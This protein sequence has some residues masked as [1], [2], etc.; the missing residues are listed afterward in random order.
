MRWIL[1]AVIALS[2]IA[3][4]RATT[5]YLAPGTASPAGRD[6]NT[7]LDAAHP[8]LSPNHSLNCG[9][10]IVAAAGTYSAWNFQG[11][12][13]GTVS[14]PANNNVAMLTCA[15]FDGCKISSTSF[16][17]YVSKSY[18]G[19]S[20]WEAT[21]SS[22]GHS[23]FAAAPPQSGATASIHH[24]IFAN[25]IANGA[26][27]GGFSTFAVGAYGV[28]Y[29]AMIGDIAYNAAQNS[30]QCYSGFSIYR[31]AQ[32][33]SV[34]GTHIYLAGNYSFGN[35]QPATCDPHSDP[36]PGADGYIIDT[37][38]G[39]FVGGVPDSGPGRFTAQ[40]ALENNYAIGN[41]GRGL[42]VQDNNTNPP[43]HA[44]VFLAH[45]TDWGNV[46]A[47]HGSSSLCADLQLNESYGINA[48]ANL[49]VTTQAKGCPG[50]AG[51]TLYPSKAWN[52]SSSNVPSGALTATN[53]PSSVTGNL[54]F[55]PNGT[56]LS[57]LT[58][59]WNADGN[60][61]KYGSNVT[62]LNPAFPGAAVPSAPSCGGFS[63]VAACMA[64]LRSNFTPSAKGAATYGVQAISTTSVTNGLYPQ[65]LCS[66]SSLPSG[67]VTPGCGPSTY[68]LTVMAPTNGTITG[69]LCSSGSY[70][71][72][73]SISCT[74]TPASGYT[75][76]GWSGACSGTEACLFTLSASSTVAAS[77]T[78]ILT[79]TLT[80][81]AIGSGTMRVVGDRSRAGTDY[82]CTLTPGLG[83]S[84]SGCDTRD[85]EASTAASDQR[86][87]KAWVL[88]S[89]PASSPFFQRVPWPFNSRPGRRVRP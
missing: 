7:G 47:V 41:D 28:D 23:A 45:N 40:V 20:G 59:A 70:A 21:V 19:V 9:D 56:T 8:W 85:R 36:S 73:T 57:A 35:V 64:T 77:F 10:L 74:A 62:N 66:V 79:Y 80:T 72:G 71:S 58:A 29:I 22:T 53:T 69:T 42:E 11:G 84:V 1:L 52:T 15:T 4:A 83:A 82:S 81:V 54:F 76:S 39:R 37:I 89:R 13:W 68:T 87:V 50:A 38:N 27:A 48:T 32:A 24:I 65:W 88:D 49:I 67:L 18:W 44:P 31:P 25:D 60:T 43:A 61:F 26:G 86:P 17:I 63:N 51:H 12:H 55:G 14:C 2:L 78:A 3:S 16:G 46:Y 6:A 33:D 34:T 30:R 75:F 5:Y